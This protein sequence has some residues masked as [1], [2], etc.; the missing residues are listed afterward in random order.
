MTM[1]AVFGCIPLHTVAFNYINGYIAE[2][3]CSR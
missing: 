3:R 2:R 1:Q